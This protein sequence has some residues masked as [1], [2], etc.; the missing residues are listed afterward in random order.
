VALV[1]GLLLVALV[2]VRVF[3]ELL[4]K[5]CNVGCTELLGVSSSIEK[6]SMC[7]DCTDRSRSGDREGKVR[8]KAS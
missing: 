5:L 3:K 4:L 6:G 2:A 7:M 8:P 1:E